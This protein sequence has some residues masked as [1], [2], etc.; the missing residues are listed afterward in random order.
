MI[1]HRATACKTVARRSYPV[2]IV[3][4]RTDT[5][6]LLNIHSNSS[7]LSVLILIIVVAI[8]KY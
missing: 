3:S 6:Q 5:Q 2:E 4:V 8:F 1:G 7:Y